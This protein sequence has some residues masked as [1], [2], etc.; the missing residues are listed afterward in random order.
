M[1]AGRQLRTLGSSDNRPCWHVPEELDASTT[2]LVRISR[3]ALLRT[4]WI[5]RGPED[6]GAPRQ[7]MGGCI[8]ARFRS[9]IRLTEVGGA[10]DSVA[11]AVEDVGLDHGGPD[12]AVPEELLDGADVVATGE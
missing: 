11:A 7:E 4:G 2:L 1:G 6:L 10:L 3:A 9:E 12:R 8:S 5:Y